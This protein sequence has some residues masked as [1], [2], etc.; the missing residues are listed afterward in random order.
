M[1]G[2]PYASLIA[3]LPGQDEPELHPQTLLQSIRR[4]S[5]GDHTEGKKLSEVSNI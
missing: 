4:L 1:N 2:V 5:T 3:R